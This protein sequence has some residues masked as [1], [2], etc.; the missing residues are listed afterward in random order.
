MTAKEA[1]EQGYKFYADLTETHEIW[2]RPNR[3]AYWDKYGI[4]KD[5]FGND[6][7]RKYTT[8]IVEIE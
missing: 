4:P 6:V 7:T 5:K 2:G 3:I 1:K 8:T